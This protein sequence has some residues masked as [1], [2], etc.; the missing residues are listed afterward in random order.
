MFSV[1]RVRYKRQG[2][3]ISLWTQCKNVLKIATVFIS[4]GKAGNELVQVLVC[5][6][7]ILCKRTSPSGSWLGC[8]RGVV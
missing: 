8:P 3:T 2:Q 1:H 6:Q 4:G 5:V 7:E